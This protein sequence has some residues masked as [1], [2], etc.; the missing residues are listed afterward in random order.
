MVSL[1]V[2]SG[3]LFGRV[4]LEVHLYVLPCYVQT[5][6]LPPLHNI[7]LNFLFTGFELFGL[8]QVFIPKRQRPQNGGVQLSSDFTLDICVNFKLKIIKV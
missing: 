6:E 3:N 2:K 4:Y 1:M 8:R 5:S 7:L